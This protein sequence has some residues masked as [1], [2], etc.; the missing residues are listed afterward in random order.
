M[1][2]Q[3]I[4]IDCEGLVKHAHA[5]IQEHEAFHPPNLYL[6]F[7]VKRVLAVTNRIRR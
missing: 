3:T 1:G 6:M 4:T 5:V 7:A 2:D